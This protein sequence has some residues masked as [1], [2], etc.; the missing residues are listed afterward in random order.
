[1]D[2]GL[3]DPTEHHILVA[4]LSPAV[5][6]RQL[7]ALFAHFGAVR[8]A[9]VMHDVTTGR[10]RGFG[11]VRYDARADADTAVAALNDAVFRGNVLRVTSTPHSARWMDTVHIRGLPLS[12]VAAHAPDCTHRMD[13][14]LC[15]AFTAHVGAL[16][17]ADH[18][19]EAGGTVTAKLQFASFAAARRCVHELHTAVQHAVFVGGSAAAPVMAKFAESRTSRVRKPQAGGQ[20]GSDDDASKKPRATSGYTLPPGVT[21]TPPKAL[22]SAGPRPQQQPPYSGPPRAMLTPPTLPPPYAGPLL[23]A[24]YAALPPGAF[25][26]APFPPPL[27]PQQWFGPLT[28][29]PP[30]PLPPAVP[31]LLA[32]PAMLAVPPVFAVPAMAA[33]PLVQHFPTQAPFAFP[34]P[35]HNFAAHVAA[36]VQFAAP[37]MPHAGGLYFA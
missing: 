15:A 35:L 10:H 5:D 2:W 20:G 21:R 4:G 29:A 6:D 34:A 12:L 31:G 3:P 32:H 17:A 28:C 11:L 24:T 33:P 26:Q 27:L 9:A 1:V 36:P 22:V 19:V 7:L 23:P 14:T 30:P 13:P 16:V 25:A 18:V 8:M 37:P